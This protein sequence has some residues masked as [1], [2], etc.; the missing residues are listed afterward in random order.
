M[1]TIRG[2]VPIMLSGQCLGGIGVSGTSA[3][4]DEEIAELVLKTHKFE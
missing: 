3:Q 1:M 4:E 2:G